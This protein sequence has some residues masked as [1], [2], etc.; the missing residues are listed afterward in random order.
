MKKIGKAAVLLVASLMILM[1]CSISVYG[2]DFDESTYSLPPDMDTA[3]LSERIVSDVNSCFGDELPHLIGDSDVDFSK[4]FKI[5]IDT[6][7]FA[8]E[9]NNYDEVRN[10]LEKGTYIFE[11]PIY[12]DN[13]D[14]YVVNIARNNPM[15]PEAYEL[16]TEEMV[17]EYE[18]TVGEWSINAI[19]QYLADENPFPDYYASLKD[20]IDARGSKPLL[21]GSLP[22]F[23][24][25][26]AIFPDDKGNLDRIYPYAQ[27]L[28]GDWYGNLGLKKEDAA[29]GFD[30][31][32]VKNAINAN[33]PKYDDT[34]GGGSGSNA[35]PTILTGTITVIIIVI[36][37]A[38]FLAYRKLSVSKR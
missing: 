26:V 31:L 35:S 3:Q 1:M 12:F 29:Q 17:D 33:P 13:G 15:T 32:T 34:G 6:N 16:M 36:A 27:A 21:V 25:A 24:F 10:I 9:T 23:R 30:Y 38:C 19:F 5:Y 11:V 18:P 22:Y 4:A 7:I 28:G 37:G 8:Q 20:E 14:V 2:T